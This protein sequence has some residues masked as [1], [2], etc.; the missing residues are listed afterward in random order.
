MALKA[1]AIAGLL[2]LASLTRPALA[3]PNGDV[4]LAAGASYRHVTR[5]DL[6]QIGGA[7][8]YGSD[9][10]QSPGSLSMEIGAGLAFRAG[11]ELRASAW[12]GVGGLALAHVEDRYFD[13]GPGQIG[14]S[15]TVGT[16]ASVRYAPELTP[17]VRA[18]VGPAVDWKRLTAAS[19]AGS[20]H[21]ELV[22]VGLDAGLRFRTS[23]AA[24]KLGGHV[25]LTFGARRELP[26]G[27]WVGRSRSDVSFSGVESAGDP[28]YSVGLGAAYVF[29]FN[30]AL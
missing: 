17:A 24:S 29:S 7:D 15:L 16:G 11:F 3:E 8:D 13:T 18:F 21:L 14:S 20:A 30:D 28:V 10:D 25:E 23:S 5:V 22:G 27:V 2:A 6:A 19:P 1:P 4:L 26:V 12:L 9:G